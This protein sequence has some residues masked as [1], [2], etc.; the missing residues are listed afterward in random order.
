MPI[1]EINLIESKLITNKYRRLL[2][3]AL[4]HRTA[5]ENKYKVTEEYKNK[6]K[7]LG[8]V[9]NEYNKEAWFVD[10]ELASGDR[11]F[12][13]KKFDSKDVAKNFYDS[14]VDG[15]EENG[16]SAPRYWPE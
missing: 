9:F 12:P 1:S 10:F 13:I 15:C 8:Q 2:V 3:V 14:I 11:F 7:E 6:L 5:G 4:T 16:G